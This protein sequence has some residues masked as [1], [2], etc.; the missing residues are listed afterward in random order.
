VTIIPNGVDIPAFTPKQN[1]TSRVLLFL[2]RIHPIKGLDILLPAWQAVHDKFP[3][4]R[5]MIA[6]PDNNGYLDQMQH[7]AV[8][9]HLK[10]I[11]FVGA[12]KG[13]HKWEAFRESD[14]FVLPTYSEYFGMTVVEALAA[15]VPAIV[16][17]GAPW[18]GLR[19]KR[20][21]GGSTLVSTRWSPV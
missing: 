10:R 17:K 6:G 8:Q 11:E 20:Q 4:W 3:D 12:L 1:R 7:L 9:L 18:Q 21:V 15:G 19:R 5:L 14:I 16:S 2:G 13:R